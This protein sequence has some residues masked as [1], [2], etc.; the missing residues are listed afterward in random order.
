MKKRFNTVMIFLVVFI[1]AFTACSCSASGANDNSTVI[2]DDAKLYAGGTHLYSAQKTSD[3]LIKKGVTDYKILLAEGADDKLIEAAEDMKDIVLKATGAR[4]EIVYGE[5]SSDK[6]VSVGDTPLARSAAVSPTEDLDELGYGIKTVGKNV[7]IYGNSDYALIFG[8]YGFLEAQFNFENFTD[9]YYYI[10]KTDTVVLLDFDVKEVPDLGY[11]FVC[12]AYMSSDLARIRMKQIATKE[13]VVTENFQV[14]TCEVYIPS[15]K[16]KENHSKWFAYDCNQLCFSAHGDATERTALVNEFANVFIKYLKS[17]PTKNVIYFG[18]A[19]EFSWCSCNACN[20]SYAKYSSNAAVVIQLLNDVCELID[21]WM[22]SDDGK[23]YAR[24]Y[25][26]SFLAYQKTLTAPK[27]VDDSVKCCEHVIA[28]VCPYNLDLQ[29]S[30]YDEVNSGL[31]KNFEEW[32][33]VSS[34]LAYFGYFYRASSFLHFYDCYEI[35]RDLF[36]YLAESNTRIFFTEAPQ[37]GKGSA[38]HALRTYVLSKLTWNV[39]LD[40]DELIDNFCERYYLDAAD[41]MRKVFYEERGWYNVNRSALTTS[42]GFY[43]SSDLLDKKYWPKNLLL[44]W[45][46]ATNE[47][48]ETISYLKK[49]NE[50]LY[51]TLYQNITVERLSFEYMLISMYERE[52][53]DDFVHTLKVQTVQDIEINNVDYFG[54]NN[55]IFDVIGAWDL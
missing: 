13:M 21:E 54:L 33:A 41:I 7:F 27:L 6:V 47:A 29:N 5:T 20:E 10:D 2:S 55:S 22:A 4:F 1:I 15:D 38:Y 3:Y 39:N 34:G 31:Y 45:Y 50:D 52:L 40:I 46:E 18:Q 11:P 36:V 49:T 14:H 26:I 37:H 19:D 17:V 53:S 16:Y 35:M 24:D 44:N 30:L 51:D 28:M 9:D 43:G 32:K 12:S 42:S 25:L 48:L 23:E 8:I